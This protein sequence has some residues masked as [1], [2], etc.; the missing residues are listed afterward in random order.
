MFGKRPDGTL[1]PNPGAMRKF[2]P[3]ISP[4]RNGSLVY[5]PMDIEVEAALRFVEAVNQDRDPKRPV[6]LFHVILLS[7]AKMFR[8]RPRM[9][10]FTKGGRLWQRDGVWLTFSAK[11][12]IS[13]DAPMITVKRLIDPDGSLEEMVDGLLDSLER[14]RR[15]EQTTSDKEVGLMLRLPPSGIR[16][17][18]WAADRLDALGMLP[19]SMIRPDPM[20]ASAFVANLG[21][22]GLDA[23]Y[24]HLW[25][26]GT[27][28]AFVVIGRIRPGA[29][30]RRVLTIKYSWDERVEDG[31]YAAKS[32]DLIKQRIEAP[33]K[34]SHDEAQEAP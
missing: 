15:G 12:R 21:S 13:D 24:H 25:E 19:L 9:N 31:L 27:C 11:M 3:F 29:D 20:Y 5:Y 33:E 32:L 23:G 6:T 4:Q 18:M 26:H 16:P 1:V 30:G 7:V 34:L 22:V 28:S 14:G 8:D 10:R 17:L 2:L